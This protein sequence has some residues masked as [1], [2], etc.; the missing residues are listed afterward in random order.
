MSSTIAVARALA[1]DLAECG[2][3]LL[4]IPED[5]WFKRKSAR[6]RGPDLVEAL[7]GFANAD[8]GTIIVGLSSGVVE[9][10]DT[11]AERRRSDWRQARLDCIPPV[12]AEIQ[13]VACAK[14]DGTPVTL[15]LI[16]V[17]PSQSMHRNAAD[18]VFLR[19]GDETRRLSYTQRR[20]LEYDKGQAWYEATVVP[21]SRSAAP[22][23]FP[24]S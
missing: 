16:E 20:E 5:Q 1:H 12:R 8:G 3:A 18:E 7:I 22:V 21:G 4:A 9:G 11:V 2:V 14:T 6:L 15:I 24:A 10:T 13:E 17:E 23:V 19:V